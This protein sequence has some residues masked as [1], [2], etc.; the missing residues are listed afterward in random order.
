[1]A[2]LEYRMLDEREVA[3]GLAL[4]PGWAVEGAKIE[5]TFPFKTYKDGLVFAVAVGHLADRLDHHPDLFVGY[6]KVRVASSTHTVDGLS[7]FDLELA[8]RIEGL[9]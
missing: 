7:P 9:L 8:K 6:R 1:M 2:A 3:D 5:K 4:L